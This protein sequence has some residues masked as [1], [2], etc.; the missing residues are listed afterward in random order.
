MA[1]KKDDKGEKDTIEQ[2]GET[3]AEQMAEISRQSRRAA[4][5]NIAQAT[6]LGRRQTEQMRTLMSAGNRLSGQMGQV[7]QG[8]VDTFVQT[9]T[10]LAKGVQDMS[11]EMMSYTQQSLQLGLRTANDL[12]TCRTVE[13]ML[14]VHSNFV[15]QSMDTFLQESA[16]L[17]DMSTSVAG[18]ATT[19]IQQRAEDMQH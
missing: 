9:G 4:E 5:E 14:K 2:I 10:R 6:E 17:M 18:E 3:N 15:R 1:V 19:P 7:A 13:D 16:K 12:M 8:D 11:W